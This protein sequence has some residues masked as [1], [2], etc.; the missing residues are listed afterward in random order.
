MQ[1]IPQFQSAGINSKERTKK[2]NQKSIEIKE[3]KRKIEIRSLNFWN[4]DDNTYASTNRRVKIW[5]PK[6]NKQKKLKR[7]T[8]KKKKWKNKVCFFINFIN[9]I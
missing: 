9:F 3:K 6:I 4:N 2:R 8:K 7:K 1:E 5:V